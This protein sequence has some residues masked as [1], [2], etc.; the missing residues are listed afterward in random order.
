M[1]CI[2]QLLL[3]SFE[4]IQKYRHEVWG[5]LAYRYISIHTLAKTLSASFFISWVHLNTKELLHELFRLFPTS[6]Q[7][8]LYSHRSVLKITDLWCTV[9]ATS[10]TCPHTM[11]LIA[12]YVKHA[13]QNI[14]ASVP[15]HTPGKSCLQTAHA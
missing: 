14:S 10:C 6:T 15:S 7:Y 12:V 11:R 9:L 3:H 8:F 13:V 5:I 4:N 1:S 2:L